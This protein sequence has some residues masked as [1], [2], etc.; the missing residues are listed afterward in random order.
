MVV[1]L[2]AAGAS[3]AAA[4]LYG[5][6]VAPLPPSSGRGCTKPCAVPQAPAAVPRL[7]GDRGRPRFLTWTARVPLLDSGGSVGSGRWALVLACSCCG[8][9]S[10]G[11][12]EG[13]GHPHGFRTLAAIPRPAKEAHDGDDTVHESPG[14]HQPR[15]A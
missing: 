14:H 10:L 15:R 3:F 4:G 8:R 1:K 11:A 7:A 12:A 5:R 6:E 2:A 9:A 13:S